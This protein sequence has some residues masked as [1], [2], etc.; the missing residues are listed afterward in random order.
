MISA[1]VLCWISSFFLVES[2]KGIFALEEKIYRGVVRVSTLIN[3][4]KH[5]PKG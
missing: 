5:Y 4:I 2:L 1:Y 3:R